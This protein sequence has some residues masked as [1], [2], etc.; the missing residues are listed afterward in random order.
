MHW[1]VLS[2]STFCLIHIIMALKICPLKKVWPQNKRPFLF[3]GYFFVSLYQLTA[4]SVITQIH[5]E[6]V[7]KDF[8]NIPSVVIKNTLTKLLDD[9]SFVTNL[10]SDFFHSPG[11]ITNTD[12]AD[13]CMCV[14]L[15]V[16]MNVY[17]NIYIH[18]CNTRDIRDTYFPWE[19]PFCSLLPASKREN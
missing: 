1:S 15:C 8:L 7:H 9:L 18:I 4:F 10:L 16:C 5:R 2:D 17:T 6:E 14:S 11:S 12:S 19:D 13:S 3:I